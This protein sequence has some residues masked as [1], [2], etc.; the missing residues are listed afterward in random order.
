[1]E[2]RFKNQHSRDKDT[3]KDIAKISYL[4]NPL[5]LTILFVSAILTVVTAIID[6]RWYVYF[7]FTIVYLFVI[8]FRAISYV[9]VWT[10]RE[11][12]MSGDVP[13]VYTM[14]FYDDK[15]TFENSIGAKR[16]IDYSTVKKVIVAK[17]HYFLVTK[18]RM[19]FTVKKGC[20]TIGDEKEFVKFLAEKGYAIK[21]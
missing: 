2:E 11:K 21:S 20:F 3:F 19:F 7:V 8:L 14:T 12:E 9:K 16:D 10:K 17:N 6:D 15:I 5:L 13:M 1:M 4:K 18:Q